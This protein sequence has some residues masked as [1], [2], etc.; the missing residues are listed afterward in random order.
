M[1]SKTPVQS[2]DSKGS[3][4]FEKLVMWVSSLSIAAMAGLLASLKQVNPD[5]EMRFT[6]GSA[7]AFV[8]GG[9]FTALFIRALLHGNKKRR[10]GLVVVA[11]ILSVLSYFLVSINKTAQANRSDVTVGTICA[12]GALSIVAWVLWSLSRFLERDDAQNRGNGE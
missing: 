9:V 2:S 10:A 4:D 7:I 3:P 5:I 6:I 1:A 12:I 8:A 11:A